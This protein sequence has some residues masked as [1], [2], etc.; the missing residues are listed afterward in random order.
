MA[1]LLNIPQDFSLLL[2]RSKQRFLHGT[3]VGVV[4]VPGEVVNEPKKI[5][6]SIKYDVN[7]AFPFWEGRWSVFIYEMFALPYINKKWNLIKQDSKLSGEEIYING[8]CWFR[9]QILLIN[10]V[11][12]SEKNVIT[13]LLSY[14]VV[15]LKISHLF[16]HFFF[17]KSLI[18]SEI[19]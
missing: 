3:R 5:L 11:S 18:S 4:L 8:K 7:Y 2:G 12:V 17:I 15:T 14:E 1:T 16:I 10:F 6:R 9:L 13:F 19:N